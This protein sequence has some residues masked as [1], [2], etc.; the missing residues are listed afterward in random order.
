[1]ESPAP[2]RSLGLGSASALVVASMV[3]AGV[4]TTSGFAL[5]DL[6]R[7]GPVLW[8][9]VVGGL[10][11]LCGALSYGALARRLPQSG[12][13]YHFLAAVIHPFA[14]FLAGWISLLAG[15]TAPIA[16][17]AL[18]IH[19]YLTPLFG[20]AL[21]AEWL[22]T[23]VILGAAAVHSLRRRQ[24]LWLQ[25]LAVAVNL[26]LMLG[27]VVYGLLHL[28]QAPSLPVE[29]A[30]PVAPVDLGAFAVSVIWITFSYSGWN[31]ATYVAGE[32]RNPERN[33]HRSLW[34]ATTGVAL[35]Y[36]ALNSVFLYSAPVEDL[37]GKAEIG[38]VAAAA[39]GGEP[40][41][42][43]ASGLVA[44][45]LFTSVLSM[46][47][48][49]PRVYARMA[50][51]G[52]F[53]ARFA[54]RDGVPT[55]SILLQAVLSILAVWAGSLRDLLSYIGFTLGLSAA[56][57]VASLFILRH[58]QGALRVPAAGYPWVPLTFLVSTIGASAFM[59]SR[60]PVKAALGLLTV[61]SGV[62]VYF[63]MRYHGRLKLPLRSKEKL[64]STN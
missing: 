12:G 62:P 34:L 22:G 16:A 25:N 41:R 52:L 39:L 38:A 59:V 45:A 47:M 15:F 64:S 33:L 26:T 37:A 46:V 48:S 11:S 13:E 60:E 29:T 36:L 43:A 54:A 35:L 20:H 17:A 10:L 58:R 9:W 3:G 57:T 51:D 23:V 2:P 44:L 18:G 40:L 27:F 50:E 63:W 55:S 1:M 24:G 21:P 5:Q 19:A 30:P 4:F 6:G 42:R 31:A 14:G 53:P 28:P 32:V 61:V 49:G 8:A 56:L 7:P